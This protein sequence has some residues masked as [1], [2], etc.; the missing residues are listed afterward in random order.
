MYLKITEIVFLAFI[1][2]FDILFSSV[3]LQ[4]TQKLMTITKNS[5]F[6]L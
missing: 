4:Y 3:I 1:S 2:M 6:I 5:S